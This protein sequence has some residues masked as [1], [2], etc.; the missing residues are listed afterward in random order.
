MDRRSTYNS[1]NADFTLFIKFKAVFI[2]IIYR[3]NNN[4]GLDAD[5][6]CPSIWIKRYPS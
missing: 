4:Y 6:S 5:V 1:Q 2:I 3:N